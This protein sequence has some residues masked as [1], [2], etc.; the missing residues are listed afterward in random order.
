MTGAVQAYALGVISPPSY[1]QTPC[2]SG[3]CEEHAEVSS[4][5]QCLGSLPKTFK[6]LGNG[7]VGG[8]PTHKSGTWAETIS[9]STYTW[10][11]YD[12]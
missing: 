12:T 10:P 9:C 7:I 2:G 11:L 1:A 5:M 3:I 4:L 8:V 6:W